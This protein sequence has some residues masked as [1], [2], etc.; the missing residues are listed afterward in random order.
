MVAKLP[1]TMRELLRH[2]GKYIKEIDAYIGNDKKAFWSSNPFICEHEQ[3]M[4]KLPKHLQ[5]FINHRKELDTSPHEYAMNG[6]LYRFP[7]TPEQKI[8]EWMNGINHKWR[9]F[10]HFYN[11]LCKNPEMNM[12]LA[13]YYFYRD[14]LVNNFKEFNPNKTTKEDLLSHAKE[15]GN[16]LRGWYGK[17]FSSSYFVCATDFITKGIEEAWEIVMEDKKHRGSPFR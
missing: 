6:I 13:F 11:D 9:S 16:K 1:A 4:S 3:Y 5:E 2:S 15:L 14:S 17:D 8:D 7:S 10:H 12:E